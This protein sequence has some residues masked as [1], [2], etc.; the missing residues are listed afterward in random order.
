MRCC[1]HIIYLIVRDGLSELKDL[2]S[3]IRNIRKYVRSSPQRERRFKEC[4]EKEGIICK[5]SLCL[6]S[7][8]VPTRW[9]STYLILRTTLKFRKAFERWNDDDPL[10]RL[11]LSGE[12]PTVQ[13]RW[14]LEVFADF[15]DIFYQATLKLFDSSYVIAN[16][17]SLK[18]CAIESFIC[19][20]CPL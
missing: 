6:E 3:R 14:M 11:K 8:D 7:L 19:K 17:T 13:I 15:L 20:A 1:A 10:L 9:N 5:S 4:V 2:I 16:R 12:P 18:F